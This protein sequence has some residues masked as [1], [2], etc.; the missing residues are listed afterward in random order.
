MGVGSR[1]PLELNG[2]EID[3]SNEPTRARL[4]SEA[5]DSKAQP[6]GRRILADTL[7]VL[8]MAAGIVLLHFWVAGPV[9]SGGDGGNWLA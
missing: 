6:N 7:I 2:R 9:P 4:S 5:D 8:G 3:I 1:R